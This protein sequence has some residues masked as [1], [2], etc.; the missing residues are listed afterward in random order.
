MGELAKSS[1]T[2]RVAGGGNINNDA[3]RAARAAETRETCNLYRCSQNAAAATFSL[4]TPAEGR[5]CR[6][7]TGRFFV[8]V[9][10][11]DSVNADRLPGGNDAST[12]PLA[13]FAGR[14]GA[15]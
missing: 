10:P 1:A 5:R 13:P 3:A 4:L 11:D 15:G 12:A 8:I 2:L 14:M 9:A 7:W 6:D